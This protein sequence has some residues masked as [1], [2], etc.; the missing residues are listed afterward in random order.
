M[1]RFPRAF[2][3]SLYTAALLPTVL[4]SCSVADPP[5]KKVIEVDSWVQ[6]TRDSDGEPQ[7][8]QTAIVRYETPGGDGATVD[9]IA[10]VHVGQRAYYENLNRRFTEYDN[11]LYELVAPKGT[12]VRRD[13]KGSSRHPVGALQN[14]MKGMLGLE[15]QLRWIDYTKEN[16]VHADMSPKQFSERMAERGESF[17]S[18]FFRL[19][20][21]SIA[22][23]SKQ[24]AQGKSSD[25]N[26]FA[27]LFSKHRDVR[28]RQ[29]M[30]EQLTGLES[31]MTSFGG[32]D[33][34]TIIT[35]RN[36]EALKVLGQQLAA[37]HK[38]LAIFYGAGHMDDMD[39]RLR[40]D[41]GLRPVSI[42]WVDAWDL[43]IPQDD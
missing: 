23:Q 3:V 36:K 2:E 9:L 8:M 13:S 11:L 25:F 12:K 29:V 38:K 27:A 32:S 21:R 33:G 26:L 17:T 24:Q 40:K 35:E 43:R 30:A 16:F 1:R 34:S 20:G 41:F 5:A 7:A 31:L 19:M 6:V 10:A 15:H 39:Q 28:L 42:Q 14:G 18:M 37:G 4:V 22:E